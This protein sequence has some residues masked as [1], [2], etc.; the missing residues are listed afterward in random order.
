[1]FCYEAVTGL[2]R[3]KESS[4]D[5]PAVLLVFRDSLERGERFFKKEWPDARAIADPDG[6][7]W[8]RFGI[9]KGTVA[10]LMRPNVLLGAIRALWKGAQMG[11]IGSVP[12]EE[13][14]SENGAGREFAGF[15]A[16]GN[17]AWLSANG[18]RR[19]VGRRGGGGINARDRGSSLQGEPT[20]PAYI[21]VGVR[22]DGERVA[23]SLFPAGPGGRRGPIRFAPCRIDP[24]KGLGA[25]D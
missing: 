1:M 22:G 11:K 3:A 2:R 6:V 7:R 4:P 12:M 5:Y 15:F 9:P 10:T 19:R 17:D 16:A 23:R 14:G 18:R 21:R 13:P 24:G 8:G 25:P 20:R